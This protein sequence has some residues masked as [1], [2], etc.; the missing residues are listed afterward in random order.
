[1]RMG[2]NRLQR[3]LTW[4]PGGLSFRA[5]SLET[6]AIIMGPIWDLEFMQSHPLALLKNTRSFFH[7][8]GSRES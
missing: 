3:A 5:A 7:W 6:N 8:V 2:D 1:M 4:A